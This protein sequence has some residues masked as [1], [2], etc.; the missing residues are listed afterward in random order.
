MRHLRVSALALAVLAPLLAWAQPTLAPTARQ[1]RAL[2]E[3]VQSVT[4]VDKERHSAG[5]RRPRACAMGHF[6]AFP[7][8]IV[9]QVNLRVVLTIP[10]MRSRRTPAESLKIDR[11]LSD[12]REGD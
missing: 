2:T 8:S 4:H 7:L 11:Q 6:E 5:P 12:Q 9:R 3:E 1:I 10:F